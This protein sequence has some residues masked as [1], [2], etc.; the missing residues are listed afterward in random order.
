MQKC[1]AGCCWKKAGL[2]DAGDHR[3]S[4]LLAFGTRRTRRAETL[5]CCMHSF[6]RE[7]ISFRRVLLRLLMDARHLAWPSL[8]HCG[9]PSI[10]SAAK[11]SPT[12]ISIA[13]SYVPNK[14]SQAT[15]A[16]VLTAALLA[17]GA[18]FF[19]SGKVVGKSQPFDQ[20]ISSSRCFN[21]SGE[22]RKRAS[23]SRAKRGSAR[24]SMVSGF[25]PWRCG[26]RCP[27]CARAAG[28]HTSLNQ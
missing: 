13:R 17:G 23:C 10:A 20:H 26:Q 14:T 27:R 5:N 12:R 18:P 2:Q 11:P 21:L 6:D 24:R 3:I 4:S 22:R 16:A 15:T 9:F 7:E 1:Y 28:Y 19:R 25:P 8:Q